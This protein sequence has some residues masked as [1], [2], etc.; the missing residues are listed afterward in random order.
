MTHAAPADLIG[1]YV[2]DREN[3]RLGFVVRHALV[4]R[5]HGEFRSFRGTAHV[6]LVEPS[7]SSAEVEIE[8]VSISTGNAQRD[9]HLRTGDFL[10]VS[11][12]PLIRYR[13]TV[14]SRI[15]NSWLA[16]RGDLTIRGFTKPL[17]MDFHYRGATTDES[18]KVRLAFTATTDISRRAWGVSWSA[19]V[20]AGGVVVADR[21]TLEIDVAVVRVP[22]SDAA[23]STTNSRAVAS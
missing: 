5:V 9:A 16:V 18:G 23:G 7:R 2:L 17:S 6:D 10:D 12:H 21:V 19:P 22:S 11:H 15:N 1:D 8:S 4:A 20:E 3:T 14:V 13:T